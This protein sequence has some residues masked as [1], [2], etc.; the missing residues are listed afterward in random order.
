MGL[1]VSDGDFQKEPLVISRKLRHQVLDCPHHLLSSVKG[2][3]I[4]GEEIFTFFWC[5]VSCDRW[6]WLH[7]LP[8]EIP[9]ACL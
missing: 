6:D 8:S 7:G 1:L 4:H 9:K 3:L 5:S 2:V